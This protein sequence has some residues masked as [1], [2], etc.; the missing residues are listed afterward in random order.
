MIS[1]PGNIV[2]YRR[3]QSH[4]Q[5]M[6][7][8]KGWRIHE[9]CY[10]PYNAT[11]FA[12]EMADDGYTIVE[13]RQGMQT[14]SEPTKLFRDLVVDGKLVHDGSPLLRWCVANA[15]QIQDSNENIKLT[16]KNVNDTKRI[17]LLAAIIDALVRIQS[18]KDATISADE[19]GV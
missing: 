4:I 9:L 18:L 1:T 7:L 6:E 2:D 3:V 15:M 14:L 8:E 5:D 13:I 19:I 12:T 11:H 16:K 17:D 10:D